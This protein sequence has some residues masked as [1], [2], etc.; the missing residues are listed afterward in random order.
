MRRKTMFVHD[1]VNHPNEATNGNGYSAE[2]LRQTR[3]MRALRQSPLA[4][5][6]QQQPQYVPPTAQS[7]F[8]QPQ[9]VRPPI[10]VMRMDT[11]MPHAQSGATHNGSTGKAVVSVITLP[12]RAFYSMV[13]WFAGE[14]IDAG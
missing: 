4:R 1:Y 8:A 7:Q 9:P 11:P 2:D 12:F 13:E 3:Q 10:P 5:A 6:R 14:N